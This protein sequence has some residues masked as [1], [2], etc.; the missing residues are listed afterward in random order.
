M[1]GPLR[2]SHGSSRNVSRL[3]LLSPMATLIDVAPRSTARNRRPLLSETCGDGRPPRPPLGP[4]PARPPAPALLDEPRRQQLLELD[5][6]ASASDP[7]E[8][9]QGRA[10][11]RPFIT[12]E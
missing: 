7:Y 9:A 1:S 4:A 2:T 12:K 5:A 8:P 3:S 10:G 11:G 6:E